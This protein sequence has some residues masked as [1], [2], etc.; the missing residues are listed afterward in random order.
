MIEG[1]NSSKQTGKFSGS[2]S[3]WELA[4]FTLLGSSLQS[5]TYVG[6]AVGQLANDHR[7][8]K[9]DGAVCL[10]KQQDTHTVGFKSSLEILYV[11]IFPIVIFLN[12]DIF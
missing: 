7:S 4:Q 10:C 12:S 8:S 5:L 3:N 9:S 6:Q 2:Q 11:Q 1:L